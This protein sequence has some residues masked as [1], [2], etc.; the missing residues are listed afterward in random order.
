MSI[1]VDI[2]TIKKK[3]NLFHALIDFLP[4]PDIL[5][6]MQI[7]KYIAAVLMSVSI[8]LAGVPAQAMQ[9]CPMMKMQEEMATDSMEKAHDCD[10]AMQAQEEQ[11]PSG[12]CDDAAC[13]EQCSIGVSI[14]MPDIPKA[15]S[16]QLPQP[17]QRFYV[18]P[19]ALASHFLNTQDRPPKFL[20]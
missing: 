11:M 4:S 19:A 16:S 15:A 7:V 10:S 13:I 17:S 2:S 12:C 1:V 14:T 5:D 9:D 8:V 3:I 18:I 20:A 6:H